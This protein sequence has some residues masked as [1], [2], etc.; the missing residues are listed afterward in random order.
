MKELTT[1]HVTPREASHSR[2]QRLS[3]LPVSSLSDV[4]TDVEVSNMENGW[5]LWCKRENVMEKTAAAAA[6][7]TGLLPH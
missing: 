4:T 7:P 5:M 3:A 1:R 6:A 2:C